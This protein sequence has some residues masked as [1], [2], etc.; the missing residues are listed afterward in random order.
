MAIDP[1]RSFSAVRALLGGALRLAPLVL[2]LAI[3]VLWASALL[4]RA[5]QQPRATMLRNIEIGLCGDRVSLGAGE[6]RQNEKLPGAAAV[7]HVL[8]E[9][10]RGAMTTEQ[11][12]EEAKA[13]ESERDW[14]RRW[15]I[16][17]ESK[18]RRLSLTYVD[19]DDPTSR[20]TFDSDRVPL[21]VNDQIQFH[22]AHGAAPAFTV[23]QIDARSIEFLS[24]EPMGAS[25]RKFRVQAVDDGRRFEWT[26]GEAKPCRASLLSALKEGVDYS[27]TKARGLIGAFFG[28]RPAESTVAYIGGA[29]NCRANGKMAIAFGEQPFAALKLQYIPKIGFAIARERAEAARVL[30]IEGRDKISIWLNAVKNEMFDRA[31]DVADRIALHENDEVRFDAGSGPSALTVKKVDASRIELQT[32]P[33]GAGARKYEL[34]VV[35]GRARLEGAAGGPK[36]CALTPEEDARAGDKWTIAY[37][38]GAEDCLVDGKAAIA[39]PQQ[40][41]AALKLQYSPKTGFTLAREHAETARLLRREGSA[42]ASIWLPK[43]NRDGGSAAEPRLRRYD[44]E[45]FVAG[46]TSYR[47]RTP[48]MSAEEA[49]VAF[50]IEPEAGQH[51]VTKTTDCDENQDA[52]HADETTFFERH[53]RC[54]PKL[55]ELWRKPLVEPFGE[56]R[57]LALYVGGTLFERYWPPSTSFLKKVFLAAL[58]LALLLSLSLRIFAGYSSLRAAAAAILAG[59]GAAPRCFTRLVT[60]GEG[61]DFWRVAV[62]LSGLFIFAGFLSWKFLG[63]GDRNVDSAAAARFFHDGAHL[64]PMAPWLAILAWCFAAVAVATSRGGGFHDGLLFTLWTALVALGHTALTAHALDSPELRH[65]RFAD[66]TTIALGAAAGLVIFAAQAHPAEL[67]R[68]LRALAAARG[69]AAPGARRTLADALK[70]LSGGGWGLL[71]AVA[72]S[73]AF[74][75]SRGSV[76]PGAIA[77]LIAIAVALLVREVIAGFGGLPG[78]MTAALAVVAAALAV[79]LVFGASA[80]IAGAFQPSEGVKTLVL[81]VLA[82][83]MTLAIDPNRN[84]PLRQR[85]GGFL[86]DPLWPAFLAIDGLFAILLFVPTVRHDFSPIIVLAFTTAATLGFVAATH[87]LARLSDFL[88]LE[89]ELRRAPED[90]SRP[91]ARSR[92]ERWRRK[93]TS[94][95][96]RLFLQPLR[97]HLLHPVVLAVAL[98]AAVSWPKTQASTDGVAAR[99]QLVNSLGTIPDKA[100]DRFISWV[101]FNGGEKRETTA[102]AGAEAPDSGKKAMPLFVEFADLGKQVG[103]SRE[104]IEA[105]DCASFNDA[106]QGPRPAPPVSS[107]LDAGPLAMLADA[108]REQAL[109]PADVL[110]KTSIGLSCERSGPHGPAW[111]RD[112]ALTLPESHND[113]VGAALIAYYGRDGAVVIAALEFAFVGLCLLA[114]FRVFRWT[115]GNARHRVVAATAAYATIGFSSMLGMQWLISWLNAAGFAPVMGQ[116]ASFLSHGP[117]HF[118]LFATPAALVPI[119]ALRVHMGFTHPPRPQLLAPPAPWTLR[120]GLRKIFPPSE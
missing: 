20:I 102:E 73:F 105:S 55:S 16:S 39:I 62:A 85:R 25:P 79:W 18:S 44:L 113:F 8:F 118:L 93:A 30:R 10:Q 91:R 35:D 32:H 2:T 80:G 47:I 21:R 107:L 74:L 114:G 78:G 13:I 77:M 52:I 37:I 29:E 65:L 6:L 69:D 11:C 84:A 36:D 23:T 26:A 33:Q 31:F 76:S 5:D 66:D 86:K 92:F 81:L 95:A 51:R 72:V 109:S 17:N 97:P 61:R 100:I 106:L 56:A 27:M 89:P 120:R 38:G 87:A 50:V 119:L 104:I 108:A 24:V 45:K 111:A 7:R 98:A 110:L 28:G 115:P 60:G 103:L 43:N 53:M 117:S 71:A 40:P 48:N 96:R 63:L 116:P 88:Y 99:Q 68:G 34:R 75:L 59:V 101:E 83:L 67:A 49:K 112:Q 90:M 58:G 54:A 64:A 9:N 42:V 82:A 14:R 57:A 22:D 70:R 15:R 19:R 41:F 46:H 4:G 1:S 3:A 12:K 94:R